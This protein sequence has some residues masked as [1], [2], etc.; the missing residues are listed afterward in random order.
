MNKKSYIK[1]LIALGENETQ[2][3]KYKITD[4][5]KIA[6]SISAF[7]NNRGGSL[8]IGVK[9]NGSIVGIESDEEIYMIELAA[10]KYCKPEQ[11]ISFSI[12]RVDGKNV[13]KVDIAESI[14][15]PVKSIDDNGKFKAFYRIADENVLVTSFHAKALNKNRDTTSHIIIIEDYERNLIQYLN[16]CGGITIFGYMKLSHISRKDAEKSVIK[17][18][19]LHIINLEYHNGDCLLVLNKTD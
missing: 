11:K 18:Y 14:N 2:D 7:A 16:N 6:K 10:S 8:L 4:A 5:K 19:D 9:D 15:K 17:L 13:L 12:Y 3:F 1:S